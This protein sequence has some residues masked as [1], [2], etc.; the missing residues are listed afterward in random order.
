MENTNIMTATE[1][2][3]GP[4]AHMEYSWSND[5]REKIFQFHF[6][7]TRTND[8]LYLEQIACEI[9]HTLRLYYSYYTY[10]ETTLYYMSL[11]YKMIGYTRDIIDGKGEYT[12]TYMLIYVWNHY[13]PKLA[14]FALKTLFY[15]D[16]NTPYGSWKDIKYFCHYLVKKKGLAINHPLI[17][18]AI[19]LMTIELRKDYITF[20]SKDIPHHSKSYS[21]VSKWIPREKSNKFGWLFEE[22]A[23][24]FFHTKTAE[25]KK[26]ELKYKIQYR[27]IITVLNEQ[28]NTIQIKMCNQ[29][30]YEIDFRQVTSISLLKQAYSFLN[31]TLNGVEK[32]DIEDRRVCRENFKDYIR[33]INNSEIIRKR[34][35]TVGIGDL[36]KAAI[37]LNNLKDRHMPT[38]V[39]VWFEE[40]VQTL[41]DLLTI[42]WR[43]QDDPSYSNT[44]Y[45]MIPIVDVS[46]EESYYVAIGI[47]LKIIEKS[48]IG[49]RMM[50][51][52]GIPKWVD[53]EDSVNL[54][55][56]IRKVQTIERGL[57]VD[58]YDALEKI[59]DVIIQSEMQREDI[60]NMK[61]VILS[62]WELDIK[63]ENKETVYENI[64]SM[65]KQIGCMP[66]ILMW[67]LKSTT[68]FPS[69]SLFQNVTMISGYNP[70]LLHLFCQ[71]NTFSSY[72]LQFT[73]WNFFVKSLKNKRYEILEK[74]LLRYFEKTNETEENLEL[75]LV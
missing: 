31:M 17:S 51:L 7:L 40:N 32:Y 3:I 74:E 57:N 71:E 60:K 45:K 48:F 68:G 59:T 42:L 9:L 11:F 62:N 4:K 54:V 43:E 19:M 53:L 46:C 24:Q 18:Y 73:P 65:F 36:V 2:Q 8:L 12:L 35:G 58:L 5:I 14:I 27:K 20:L 38:P 1:K 63:K 55:D 41:S 47:G 50:I 75:I 56:M 16:D 22:L 70:R 39:N 49:K 37:M 23:C 29:R 61:F 64:Q 13:Y 25:N 30:W 6:Q 69:V 72:A 10:K 44:F 33:K 15:L 67:N 66:R 28:I 52:G 21:L 34:E 26:S